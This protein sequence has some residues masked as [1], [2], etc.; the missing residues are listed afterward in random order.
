MCIRDRLLA[1]LPLAGVA[2]GYGFGGDPLAFLAG[3]L[4]GQLSL[5][6]GVS[7]GCAGVVWTEHIA[8]AGNG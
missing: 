1:A 8:D 6:G 7:L 3:S 4:P 2:L 5:I